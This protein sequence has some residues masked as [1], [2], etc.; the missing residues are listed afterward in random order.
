METFTSVQCCSTS[1]QITIVSKKTL[2]TRGNQH[3][4]RLNS[5]TAHIQRVHTASA[6]PPCPGRWPCARVFDTPFQ[7]ASTPPTFSRRGHTDTWEHRQQGVL[8]LEGVSRPLRVTFASLVAFTT[9]AL[10]AS[11]MWRKTTAISYKF[12]A[13]AGRCT[14]CKRSGDKGWVQTFTRRQRVDNWW[15]FLP[16][17]LPSEAGIQNQTCPFFQWP[18]AGY[19]HFYF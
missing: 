11:I 15:H 4:I 19:P 17:N 1:F 18:W 5:T 7:R 16:L 12:A 3:F 6:S 9:L 13:R 10:T 8:D 2:K 14:F